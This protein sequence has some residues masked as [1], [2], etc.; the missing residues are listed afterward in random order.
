MPDKA[1]VTYDPDKTNLDGL[2]KALKK[3]GYPA[4]A[5]DE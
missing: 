4:A 3:A 1:L 2:L 5:R